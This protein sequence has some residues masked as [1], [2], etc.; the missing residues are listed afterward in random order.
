VLLAERLLPGAEEM[1]THITC[2]ILNM[3]MWHDIDSNR[4]MPKF[5]KKTG[6]N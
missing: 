5:N 3:P 2:H 1:D 6:R 4:Q